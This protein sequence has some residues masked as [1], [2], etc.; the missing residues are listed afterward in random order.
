MQKY[1]DNCDK[2]FLTEADLFVYQN[3]NKGEYY[4]C[5]CKEKIVSKAKFYIRKDDGLYLVSKID[6][7][8]EYYYWGNKKNAKKF[9]LGD[10][11]AKARILAFPVE[12]IMED[13][14]LNM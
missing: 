3:T 10:A 11:I 6:D 9:S 12:I 14:P 7:G 8:S 1:C 13:I 4:S 2:P 5:G